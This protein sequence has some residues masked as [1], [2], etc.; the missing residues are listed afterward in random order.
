MEIDHL[1]PVPPRVSK[2]AAKARDER[3]AILLSALLPYLRQ[4]LLVSD[5]DSKVALPIGPDLGNLEEGE[6]LVL[7]QR[8]EGVS[9]PPVEQPQL[10]DILV[11]SNGLSL[12]AHL[13]RDMLAPVDLDAHEVI[14]REPGA[15]GNPGSTARSALSPKRDS[16]ALVLVPRSACCLKN[17][18]HRTGARS[19][20]R[21]LKNRRHPNW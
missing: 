18:R 20:G 13:D 11:K 8:K 5:H 2:I 16:P 6:K 4:L 9:F 17:K 7:P 3:M 19:E 21:C 14:L 15:K 10:E 1:D 12:V